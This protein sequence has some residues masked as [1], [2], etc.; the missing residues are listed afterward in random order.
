MA[1][2]HS[3]TGSGGIARW[4]CEHRKTAPARLADVASGRGGSEHSLVVGFKDDQW[5]LIAGQEALQ[6]GAA[7]QASPRGGLVEV[8]VV[9]EYRCGQRRVPG[10]PRKSGLAI[11]VAPGPARQHGGPLQLGTL[12]GV[13]G[14]PDFAQ[15]P[16]TGRG[17]PRGVKAGR[18]QGEDRQDQD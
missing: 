13:E 15:P 8:D 7:E 3:L 18:T 11:D 2:P 16:A 1:R 4:R 6:P 5:I 14:Q 10:Q 9:I 12:I 17:Q